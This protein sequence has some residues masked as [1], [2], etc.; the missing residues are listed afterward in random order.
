[1]RIALIT[2]GI[3]YSIPNLVYLCLIVFKIVW[4]KLS[5]PET[6]ESP[7]Q[8][9]P[10]DTFAIDTAAAFESFVFLILGGILILGSGNILSM[11]WRI[12]NVGLDD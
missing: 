6:T 1:M 10:E 3:W 4:N 9:V 11:L 12:K 7:F 5:P 2:T 8:T